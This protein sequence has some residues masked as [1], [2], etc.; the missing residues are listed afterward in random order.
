MVAYAA[1]TSNVS[2]ANLEGELINPRVD[3]QT[4]PFGGGLWTTG[5]PSQVV[6]PRLEDA[7]PG[8]VTVA[9]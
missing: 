2:G 8:G 4:R 6:Q 9:S 1:N 7:T 3:L 5:M